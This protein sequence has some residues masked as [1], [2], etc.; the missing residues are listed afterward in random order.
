MEQRQ[1]EGG[2]MALRDQWPQGL[3]DHGKNCLY[4]KSNWKAWKCF[5]QR[6]AWPQPLILA[7]DID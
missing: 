5:K 7:G 4:S 1:E 3:L 2:R 6:V